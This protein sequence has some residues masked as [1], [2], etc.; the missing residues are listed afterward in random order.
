[1]SYPECECG[2]LKVVGLWAGEKITCPF[3]FTQPLRRPFADTRVATAHK[4]EAASSNIE[5]AA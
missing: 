4:R 2:Q 1:V 3:C 5:T